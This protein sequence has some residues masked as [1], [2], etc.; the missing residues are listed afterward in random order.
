MSDSKVGLSVTATRQNA[1]SCGNFS[2]PD[3]RVSPPAGVVLAKSTLTVEE[4][5]A[6]RASHD[7]ARSQVEETTAKARAANSKRLLMRKHYIWSPLA[8]SDYC[9]VMVMVWVLRSN[10][11]VE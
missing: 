10:W 8:V 2:L 4:V 3:G 6:L 1:G 11:F 9:T 5:S 7:S